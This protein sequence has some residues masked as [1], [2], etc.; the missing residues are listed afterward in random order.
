M[1]IIG[2][3]SYNVRHDGDIRALSLTFGSEGGYAA[4]LAEQRRETLRRLVREAEGQG[5]RLS[6]SDLSIILLSS[7]ATLKR[8][9][10]H[11]RSLGYS[12]PIGRRGR[13]G[14]H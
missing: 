8:D 1:D 4:G 3:I 2:K 12:L 7:R 14:H 13:E 6:Y 10:R 5:V 9:V 11:L